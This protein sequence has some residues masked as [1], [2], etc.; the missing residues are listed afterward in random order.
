MR[1]IVLAIAMAVATAALLAAGYASAGQAGLAD[2]A[3]VVAVTGLLLG[4]VLVRRGEPPSVLGKESSSAAVR[5][6]DF[7]SYL[8]LISD[9]EWAVLSR[10][11]YEQVLRP[12]LTSLGA[13][14]PDL[15]PAD[16]SAAVDGAGP[17]LATLDRII[18]QL[19][20]ST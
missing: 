9:L 6:E 16:A 15:G 7:P 17:D 4:R 20:E 13:V 1:R 8:R 5:R 2:M 3:V 19:E 14:P 10:R 18:T 11:H 12:R